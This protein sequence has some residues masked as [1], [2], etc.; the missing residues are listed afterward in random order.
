MS[1]TTAQWSCNVSIRWEFDH[2]GSAL[3]EVSELPFGNVIH[4]KAQVERRL[5]QAQAAI[6]SPTVPSQQFLGLDADT[7]TT[8]SK[9][10]DLLPFSRNVVCVDLEGPDLTDLSFIDLPGTISPLAQND[11]HID[12]EKYR[13]HP[14]CGGQCCPTRRRYGR[15]PHSW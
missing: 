13:N 9:R 10:K 6:L 4:D 12:I 2:N 14:E 5:R 15:F 8:M 1:S 3:A 7:L 11:A